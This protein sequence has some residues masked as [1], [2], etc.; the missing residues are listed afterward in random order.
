[1]SLHEFVVTDPSNTNVFRSIVLFG[2]NVATYKFALA[3]SL[4]HFATIGQ[5]SVTMA[6]LAVPYSEILCQH[7]KDAPKQG[8]SSGSK[9]LTACKEYNQGIISRDE[10]TAKTISLGFEN[11]IDAFHRVGTADVPTRSSQIRNL[12]HSNYT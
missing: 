8:T 3:T 7:L 4:I 2:R 11:D 5:E 6:E 12:F 1:M 9:F 10:L